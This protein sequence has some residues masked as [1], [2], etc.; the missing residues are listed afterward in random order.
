VAGLKAALE[1]LQAA[2]QEE[3]RRDLEKNAEKEK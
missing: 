1:K 3:F 2:R